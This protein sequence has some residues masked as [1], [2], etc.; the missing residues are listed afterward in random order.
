MLTSLGLDDVP[1]VD[2]V[3]FAG[4]LIGTHCVVMFVMVTMVTE[5]DTMLSFWLI[6]KA[7]NTAPVPSRAPNTKITILC[8]R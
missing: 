8:K 6:F 3:R 7:A 5:V 2:D 1:V 4:V